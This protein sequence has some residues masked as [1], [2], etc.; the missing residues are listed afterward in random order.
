MNEIIEKFD[1]EYKKSNK[2]AK[3]SNFLLTINFNQIE[4]ENVRNVAEEINKNLFSKDNFPRFLCY[5]N[6]G[7]RGPLDPK[8]LLSVRIKAGVEIGKK[9]NQTHIHALVVVKH[10]SNV[11]INLPLLKKIIYRIGSEKLYNGDINKKVYVNVKGL[12][13]AQINFEE[14]IDKD[15]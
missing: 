12:P 6:R 5:Y 10:T 7:K 8:D 3:G 11:Q 4:N 15:K 9:T 14:Y 1:H 13:N 2:K